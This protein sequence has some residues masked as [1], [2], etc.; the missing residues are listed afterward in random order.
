[1]RQKQTNPKHPF[2]HTPMVSLHEPGHLSSSTHSALLSTPQFQAQRLLWSQDPFPSLILK[3]MGL[4]TT[5]SD[6]Q[7]RSDET[8]VLLKAVYSGTS[9][10]AGKRMP[11]P[12]SAIPL[13]TLSS[14]PH[15]PSPRRHSS[16]AQDYIHHIIWSYVMVHLRNAAQGM[17]LSWGIWGRQVPVIRLGSSLGCHL[18]TAATPTPHRW[19]F[20]LKSFLYILYQYL[21]VTC[22]PTP[23]CSLPSSLRCLIEQ[24]P[25]CSKKKKKTGSVNLSNHL[26]T[27]LCS[28][29]AVSSKGFVDFLYTGLFSHSP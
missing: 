22:I 14:T 9:Q 13:Y 28:L 19:V 7:K 20:L 11:R 10:C 29:T 26:I 25:S 16:L 23:T 8:H 17:W 5:V 1:M 24:Y 27:C 15:H 6:Q 21:Y 12:L 2:P 18:G 3:R 4:V